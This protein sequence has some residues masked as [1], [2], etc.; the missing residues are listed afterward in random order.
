[1][2]LVVLCCVLLCVGLCF[3]FELVEID[4]LKCVMVLMSVGVSGMNVYE[5]LG[6]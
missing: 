4:V 3:L 2:C 6:V 1:M 5:I